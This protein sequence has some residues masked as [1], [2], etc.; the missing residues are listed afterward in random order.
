MHIIFNLDDGSACSDET[1]DVCAEC[2]PHDNLESLRNRWSTWGFAG[3]DAIE[4]LLRVGRHRRDRVDF[5]LNVILYLCFK[6]LP[7]LLHITGCVKLCINVLP[8]AHCLVLQ[9]IKAHRP[10]VRGCLF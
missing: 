7:K 3:I 6:P 2:S 10:E 5:K 9:P 1:A 4:A 8:K